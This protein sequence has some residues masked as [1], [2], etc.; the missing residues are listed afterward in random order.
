MRMVLLHGWLV[1]IDKIKRTKSMLGKVD[2]K[3]AR[4]QRLFGRV[5]L[6]VKSRSSTFLY[7]S[8]IL[9]LAGFRK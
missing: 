8:I 3:D 5:S 4:D 1:A 7:I 2:L 6:D 9:F